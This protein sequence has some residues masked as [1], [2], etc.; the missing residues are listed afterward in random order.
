MSKGLRGIA[1]LFIVTG[2][3]FGALN[4]ELQSPARSRGGIPSLLQLPILRLIISGRASLSIFF[5]LTGFV[6]SL[7]FIKQVRAGNQHVALS[8]LSRSALRRFCRMILPAAAATVMSWILCNLGAYTF[9]K[10]GEVAWF[11]DI[12]PAPKRPLSHATWD[13]IYNLWTTWAKS[14]N[15]YDKVQWNL[16]FLLKASLTVYTILLMTAYITSRARKLILFIYY[17]YGWMSRDGKL[18]HTHTHTYPQFILTGVEKISKIFG[19]T[20]PFFPSKNK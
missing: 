19:K 18:T 9:A 3:L 8:G 5:L 20:A 10:E 17:M 11:R 6:N 4:T 14:S 1:A 16:F 2:H 12:S 15:D 13:L 7:S